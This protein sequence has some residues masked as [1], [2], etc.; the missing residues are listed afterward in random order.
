M[1]R[2]E[3][4]GTNSTLSD[5][6]KQVLFRYRQ[7][8][9]EL[10]DKV[11]RADFTNCTLLREA[12]E[13]EEPC[14]FDTSWLP[15]FEKDFNLTKTWSLTWWMRPKPGSLGMPTNFWFAVKFF[16]SIQPPTL[17]NHW[18]EIRP[19]LEVSFAS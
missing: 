18:T 2:E 14:T 6:D 8:L 7:M 1:A 12:L 3:A 19:D 13:E 11:T 4:K 10:F 9:N 16:S 17:L 15:E 5:F